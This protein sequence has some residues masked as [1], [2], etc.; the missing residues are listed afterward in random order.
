MRFLPTT[1]QVELD[2]SNPE[3]LV[4]AI[5]GTIFYRDGNNLFYLINN[6]TRQR[7][8][9][10]KKSFTLKYKNQ[11]WYAT[12]EDNSI[13]FAH[14]YEM[15]VKRGP[16][17][18]TGWKFV[19]YDP[20]V[21]FE[22]VPIPPLPTAT[23]TPTPTAAPTSTPTSTPTPE[24]TGTPTPTPTVTATPTATPTPA[25]TGTPTPTPTITATPTITPTPIGPDGL[26]K[27]IYDGYFADDPTWFATATVISSSLNISPIELGYS[28]DKFSIEWVGYFRAET[29][30]D[31]TFHM[32]SDDSAF[33]WIGSSAISGY[34][35]G[36]ALVSNPGIH[37][38]I[39]NSGSISMVAGGVYP[40]R[41]QYGENLGGEIIQLA[42]STNTISKT[43]DLNTRIFYIPFPAPTAT[44]TPTPTI[45]NTPTPAPTDTPTPTP[46]ATPVP[47]TATPTLTPT[48]APTSTPT[49]T[50]TPTA[51]PLPNEYTSYVNSVVADG[52]MIANTASLLTNITRAKNEGW[53][54]NTV[55]WFAGFAGYK[56]ASVG[57]VEKWYDI[58][59]N[60]NA[61]QSNSSLLPAFVSSVVGIKNSPAMR[62][63]PPGTNQ[64]R[65]FTMGTNPTASFST[66]GTLFLVSE[67]TSSDDL[68]ALFGTNNVD[69]W[70]G[71][72]GLGNVAYPAVW[73]N[74]RVNGAFTGPN[75]GTG[76]LIWEVTT[77]PSTKYIWNINGKQYYSG[78]SVSGFGPN[79]ISSGNQYVF[80]DGH[81]RTDRTFRGHIAELIMFNSDLPNQTGSVGN[82]VTYGGYRS[83]VYTYLSSS[84]K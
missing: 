12:I 37:T 27:T 40:I 20:I 51:T 62:F 42:I 4:Y 41:I 38:P 59:M 50:P 55:S 60:Y 16:Y 45:T 68:F 10:S 78:S 8:D 17:S 28:G 11:I 48:P 39:E 19:S 18:S 2:Q 79:P 5:S 31:Y 66:A 58:K 30:E 52:G 44:P 67:A 70:W 29:T 65:H 47:P 80:P 22:G 13:V 64:Q 69:Q 57:G 53:W 46:T 81:D 15:W 82:D 34:T 21:A 84:Y 71:G 6:G 26:Y 61:T 75:G 23:P 35:V 24:P 63:D 49:I 83:N 14:P 7:I 73:T 36:N 25:P 43:T 32:N 3:G 33:L 54:S 74:D 72:T 76:S 1:R 9:V 56:T 77:G